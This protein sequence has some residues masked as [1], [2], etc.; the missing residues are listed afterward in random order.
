[1]Q[2]DRERI[3]GAGGSSH[4]YS[5]EEKT[6]FST[7]INNMLDGDEILNR[8]MPLNVN[9]EDL[10]DKVNDGLLFCQLINR[11]QPGLI[12]EK[13]IN[14]KSS[15]NIYQKTENINHVLVAA[16]SLG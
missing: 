1:M 16:K 13:S 8:L 7:C 9:S 14:K 10:F 15:M 11:I 2:Q 12:N 3:D 6:A 5:V 4:S